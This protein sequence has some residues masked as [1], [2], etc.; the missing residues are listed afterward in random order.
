[1]NS[2]LHHTNVDRQFAMWQAIYPDSWITP[3]NT[4]SGTWTIYPNTE[5]NGDTP[6]YPF[7]T[8]DGKTPWTSNS[9]RYTSTFGYSYPEVR[10]WIGTPSELSANVSAAVNRLYNPSGAL[11]TWTAGEA[12][13]PGS[14]LSSPAPFREWSVIIEVPNSALGKGFSVEV[15][16]GD[17]KVGMVFVLGAPTQVEI[18]A[19]VHKVT[20]SEFTLSFALK[21]IDT[22]NVAAVVAFLK[23]RLKSTVIILVNFSSVVEVKLILGRQMEIQFRL[24]KWM[25]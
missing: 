1:M 12:R 19:G 6:L 24:I 17:V 9:A 5:I 11:G 8:D 23:N 25:A 15:L 7:F 16:V 22:E 3:S 4:T 20:K 18:D 2:W 13:T 10:D 14:R 21:D